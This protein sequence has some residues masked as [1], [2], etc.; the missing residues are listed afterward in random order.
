MYAHLNFVHGVWS[1][2]C[3]A[4]TNIIILLFG[5]M[6]IANAMHFHLIA[7]DLHILKKNVEKDKKK[8]RNGNN[9]I[10]HKKSIFNGDDPRSKLHAS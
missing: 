10:E 7:A 6:Q 4:G 5:A 1:S 3:V 9:K 2:G 8:K